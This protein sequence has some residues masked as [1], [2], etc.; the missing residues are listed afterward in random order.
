MVKKEDRTESIRESN[1]LFRQ[2]SDGFEDIG[3]A[4][5][6]AYFNPT[7]EEMC[8]LKGTKQWKEIL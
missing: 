6:S 8:L 2:K 5:G 3:E 4:Y 7:V 1:A